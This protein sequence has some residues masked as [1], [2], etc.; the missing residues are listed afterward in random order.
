MNS[1]VIPHIALSIVALLYGANYVI[2]KIVLGS[3]LISAQGFIMLRVILTGI[4]LWLVHPILT[5]DRLDKK[6]I[7]YLLLC[8]LFGVSINQLCFF[9]GLELTSPLHAS[10]IMITTPIIVLIAS[11]LILK[12]KIRLTQVVGILI[13]L[14]GATILI[15]SASGGDD[16]ASVEGDFFIFINA[17][18]YALYLVVAKRML[19]KYHPIT[20]IKWIFL[21]G[22][23][24]I[25]PFGMP[26]LL[27]ADF[28]GFDPQHWWTVVYVVVGA[29][30]G[31]YVLN[32]FALGTVKPSTVSFYVYFQPLIA[33][34]IS[35]S[36][37]QDSLDMYKVISALLMFLG[38]YFVIKQKEVKKLN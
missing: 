28:S 38:V 27:A 23:I 14:V 30:F 34:F 35:I 7:P 3:G 18:S 9:K 33:S 29:T 20:V 22:G 16:I 26:D 31:T 24:L 4:L 15:W 6:D 37:G 19:E 21:L 17:A 25:L 5:S 36:L 8:S 11:F 1:K 10:L 32:A 12:S 13:G 2:A